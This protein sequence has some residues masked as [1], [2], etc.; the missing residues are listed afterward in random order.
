MVHED[1]LMHFRVLP[2]CLFLRLFLGFA[3]LPGLASAQSNY[4]WDRAIPASQAAL[5]SHGPGAARIN[6]AELAEV[7]LVSL[8]YG[9][10]GSSSGKNGFDFF[11]AAAGAPDFLQLPV[12]IAVGFGYMNGDNGEIDASNSTYEASEYAP[13]LAIRYPADPRSA[14]RAEAGLAYTIG[15]YNA[16]NAIRSY[17]AGI[18][19]GTAV[20]IEGRAGRFGAGF[21]Y[22]DLRSPRMRMPDENGA[23]YRIPGW[24]EYSLDWTSVHRLIR[25]RMGLFDQED[26]DRSEGPGYKGDFGINGWEAELRPVRWLGVKAERTHASNMSNL[27]VGV[28]LPPAWTY[29]E[30]S[31]ELNLGHSGRGAAAIPSPFRQILLLD[32]EA[33]PGRGWLFG[34]TL[35]VGI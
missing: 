32:K 13:G 12:G 27:G 21:A 15:E 8:T 9:L 23:E 26:Q 2:H 1:D 28:Y 19:A 22:H 24:R 17:S 4:K 35:S 30:T 34:L 3:L 20:S 31:L 18:S 10:S 16:F 11:Q 7:H 25:L 6:P 5:P 14:W 33:D 29:W